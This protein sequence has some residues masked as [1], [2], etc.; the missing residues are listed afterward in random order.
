MFLYHVL[1]LMIKV[2]VVLVKME[3]AGCLVLLR[4]LMKVDLRLVKERTFT[5]H[6]V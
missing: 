4:L 3:E 2:I 5:E 1:F 6:V